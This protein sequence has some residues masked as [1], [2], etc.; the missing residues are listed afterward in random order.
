MNATITTPTPLRIGDAGVFTAPGNTLESVQ[1][2]LAEA[3]AWGMLG[4]D[5]EWNEEGRITWVGLGHAMGGTGRAVSFWWPTLPAEARKLIADAFASPDLPKLGQNGIQADRP[6][7]ER[8]VGPTGGV[9]EDTMLLHHA[10]FPGIAHDLQQL[11][12]QFLVVPPWKAWRR[13]AMRLAAEQRREQAKADKKAQRM[14]DHDARNAQR[15]ADAE[16]KRLQKKA[17]KD[18]KVAAKAADK[19]AKKSEKQIA[20]EAKIAA[21]I[22][23]RERKKAEKIAAHEAR[24]AAAAAAGKKGRRK[25][26][27]APAPGSPPA[28]VVVPMAAE[29][30]APP[31]DDGEFPFETLPEN[32]L[33]CSA[34]GEPQRMSPIGETCV[35]QHVGAPGEE[36]PPLVIETPEEM[37][38][39]DQQP[40]VPADV[41]PHGKIRE[42]CDVCMGRG[43]WEGVVEV[44]PGDVAAAMDSEPD[45]PEPAPAPPVAAEPPRTLLRPP[46]RPVG[47]IVYGGRAA[48]LPP[49]VGAPPRKRMTVVITGADGTE[50][51]VALDP[52]ES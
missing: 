51:E 9:W 25:A 16:A 13:E 4:I 29:A 22:A 39:Q 48:S 12:A 27:T 37:G 52:E 38:G 19:E 21:Q 34:C 42:G 6:I 23:E 14:A 5:L 35:N 43:V 30:A 32:G 18:Q 36:P 15:K 1:A 26:A 40:P 28:G 17:E 7:W 11:V 45:E 2:I 24:N 44:P 41:C 3:R 31:R 47:G 20:H 33:L 46:V 49:P 50:Q 8:E 10:A